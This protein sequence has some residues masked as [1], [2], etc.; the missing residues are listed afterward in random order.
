MSRRVIG[1]NGVSEHLERERG[2]AMP[3]SLKKVF[4]Y[5]WPDTVAD[6]LYGPDLA[7]ERDLRRVE[8]E[9]DSSNW[10]LLPNLVPLVA[11][12]EKSFACV[13]ASDIDD[14]ALPGEGA[15]VRWH[16]ELVN[17]RHQAALLDTDCFLFVESLVEE[18]AVR[19]LGLRRMLYEIGPAYEESFLA[20]SERP[21]DFVVRPV[22]IACQNVIIGLAAIAQESSFDGLSVVAWQACEVAHVATHEA[23]RA[24]AVITLCDAFQNGGTMEIRFDKPARIVL[25]GQPMQYTGHPESRVPASLRRY[26]RTVGVELGSDDPGAITPREARALFEAITPMPPELRRRVQFAIAH[27]GLSPERLYFTLLKPIWRDI[28]LDYLIATSPRLE[29][30]LSGGAPW[31]DRLA[32]QAESDVCRSA[33]MT[34]MLHRRLNG[35]DAAGVD[36]A[37]RV[38]EDR[39]RGVEWSIDE[40]TGSV[41]FT[42]L[43]ASASLPWSAKLVA[44]EELTIVPRAYV[45]MDTLQE[46]EELSRQGLTALVV[47][48][49]ARLPSGCEDLTVLRCPDRLPDIDKAIEEKL[50]A[51]RISRG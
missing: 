26:G 38:V 2:L 7:P 44:T 28:E 22:R 50:L 16:T 41:R 47:A 45:T 12:D 20:K 6:L 29:S 21:R 51:A 33:V 4:E 27:L 30:I 11:L 37:A 36:G 15:V 24:L 8:E 9:I 13:V 48:A 25:D 14:T 43:D 19:P 46:I 40:S 49:G 5:S 10:P 32:R 1:S 17:D 31:T 39:K 23:N 18:L 35:S 34:G 3:P 42:G